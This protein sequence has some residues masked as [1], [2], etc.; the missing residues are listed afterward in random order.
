MLS[1]I[2]Q[3]GGQSRRM[4]QDKALMP[5]LGEPLIL[6]VLQRV[7]P[8]ADEILAITNRPSDYA[9]LKM[10]L[11]ADILPDRGAL[12]GL[13]TALKIANQPYVAVI[14]CD[15]PFVRPDLIK[16]E[17]RILEQNAVDAV[18]PKTDQGIEPFHAIYRRSSC[19]PEVEKVLE[20][21]KWRVDSW[22]GGM[23]IHFLQFAEV[24]SELKMDEEAYLKSFWNLNTPEDFRKAESFVHE[25]TRPE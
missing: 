16:F 18:I 2:V 12:G 13:Y 21:G 20:A 8:L 3:A 22:L 24:Q 7:S 11:F 25:Q 6:R 19:L 17:R 10:P 5:F 14:A 23:N 1:V 9:F 4:G 15:M